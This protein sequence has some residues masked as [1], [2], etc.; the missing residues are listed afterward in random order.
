MA[1]VF[2]ITDE[3]LDELKSLHEYINSGKYTVT[4]VVK[5]KTSF[6]FPLR[7][8]SMKSINFHVPIYDYGP[9]EIEYIMEITDPAR[10]E[11]EVLLALEARIAD[12]ESS[13]EY[14]EA[15]HEDDGDEDDE[16]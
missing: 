14:Q 5:T 16:D 11:Q 9:E 12:V 15:A 3:S 2:K 10:F 4:R 7:G 8:K 6:I 13:P 1:E